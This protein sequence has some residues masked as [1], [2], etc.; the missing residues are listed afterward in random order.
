MFCYDMCF[1]TYKICNKNVILEVQ[2]L[3]MCLA[4]GQTQSKERK[5]KGK[6]T[7]N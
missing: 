2:W 4:Q 7:M 1:I 5:K 6:T 3:G